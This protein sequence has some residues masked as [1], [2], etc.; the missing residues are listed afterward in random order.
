MNLRWS[1]QTR[2]VEINQREGNYFLSRLVPF[3]VSLSLIVLDLAVTRFVNHDQ[4]KKSLSFID[5]LSRTLFDN[6]EHSWE[7]SLAIASALQP[8]LLK[9][10]P[11]NQAHVIHQFLSDY[12]MIIP[13]NL[14]NPLLNPTGSVCLNRVEDFFNKV[15]LYFLLDN[16][17]VLY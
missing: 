8:L 14:S 7:N 13:L 3:H 6:Y 12:P 2:S 5:F 15:K 17:V 10:I 4:T 1:L 9:L 16:H 11:K